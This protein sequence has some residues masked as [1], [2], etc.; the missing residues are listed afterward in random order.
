MGF[1]ICNKKLTNITYNV[2]VLVSY[3]RNGLQK[4]LNICNTYSTTWRYEYNPSKCAV[5]VFNEPKNA[6]NKCQRTWSLG[7]KLI[8]EV[9]NYTHLGINCNKYFDIT[10]SLIDANTYVQKKRKHKKINK[11]IYS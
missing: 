10:N 1:L 8:L 7:D 11:Y 6:Y 9:E 5:I 2:L 4:M 3:S